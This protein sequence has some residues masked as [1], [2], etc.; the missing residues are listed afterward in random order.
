M[1]PVIFVRHAESE[2]N[3][4]YRELG[5]R[6]GQDY[7]GF[8]AAYERVRQHDPPL[9][10]VGERQLKY[11]SGVLGPVIRGF[12]DQALL[13]TSPMQRAVQTSMAI[14]DAAKLDR[15]CFACNLELFEAR[16]SFPHHD[17]RPSQLAARLEHDYPLHCVPAPP[18]SRY[19]QR[20]EGETETEFRARLDRSIAW[21]ENML[22]T[23]AYDAIVVVAHGGLLS[24]W[25]RRWMRVPAGRGVTFRHNNAAFTIA[26]WDRVQGLMLDALNEVSHLPAEL[27]P[28][29]SL[30][31]W[32]GYGRPGVKL[33]R[34]D[35]RGEMPAEV[36]AAVNELG[37]PWR[38]EAEGTD[39]VYLMLR[40]DREIVGFAQFTKKVGVLR[41]LVIA[42][43]SRGNGLGAYLLGYTEWFMMVERGV[44]DA[45]RAF[46]EFL[47]RHGWSVD[48]EESELAR[49]SKTLMLG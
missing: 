16:S 31:G 1:S 25:L 4:H 40:V 42:R 5:R 17:E 7:R 9:S 21:L 19:P 10:D 6:Y 29:Q 44:V 11:L 23:L 39:E 2:N 14:R 28:P 30:E 26:Y 47:S 22:D 13:V 38:V 46:V 33:Q 45:P 37:A 34:Y 8:N 24:R 20:S 12:G 49:M 32:W 27:D 3:R 41:R 43:Q 48:R 35:G 36:D 18:D 15:E